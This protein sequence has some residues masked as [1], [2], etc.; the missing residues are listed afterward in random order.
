[1]FSSS[2][3]HRSELAMGLWH[4]SLSDKSTLASYFNVNI[5]CWKGNWFFELAHDSRTPEID[6][7]HMYSRWAFLTCNQVLTLPYFGCFAGQNASYPRP[8]LGQ[9][10]SVSISG[11]RPKAPLFGPH[12]PPPP[13]QPASVNPYA[14]GVRP[15]A[16]PAQNINADLFRHPPPQVG[17]HPQQHQ[18]SSSFPRNGGPPLFS[19]PP[20][21]L[22][23]HHQQTASNGWVTWM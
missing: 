23:S 5:P 2:I 3:S 6:N 4:Q 19:Q 21:A 11:P 9:P 10:I 15:P 17:Q 8:G 13:V 22:P 7:L 20:P 16:A 14:S 18:N 12:P 1:M